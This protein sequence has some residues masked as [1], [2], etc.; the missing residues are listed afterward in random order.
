[1][2]RLSSRELALERRK[3]LT[4]AGKRHPLLYQQV[5]IAFGRPVMPARRAPMQTQLRLPLQRPQ[6]P[7]L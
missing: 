2:A 3:A 4:T 1:M 7:S 5:R 6:P